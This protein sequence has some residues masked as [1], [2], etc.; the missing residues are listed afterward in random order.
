MVYYLDEKM[1]EKEGLTVVM[2]THDPDIAF[3]ADKQYKMQDG[4]IINE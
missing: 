1:V 2:T 3:F 4:E